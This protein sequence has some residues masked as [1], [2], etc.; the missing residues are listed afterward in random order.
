MR[1]AAPESCSS[2]DGGAQA[3]ANV[4]RDADGEHAR[5]GDRANDAA[6]DLALFDEYVTNLKRLAAVPAERYALTSVAIED[7]NAAADFLQRV[8][9]CK[10]Q[11]EN[12]A[13]AEQRDREQLVA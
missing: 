4:T 3:L 9:A 8:V 13:H 2:H 1:S 12:S 11:V 5:Q 6:M 10:Q 7:L